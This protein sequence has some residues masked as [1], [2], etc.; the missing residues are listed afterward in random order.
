MHSVAF[1][2]AF[3]F[4]LSAFLNAALKPSA[5]A[6]ENAVED[7]SRAAH[8]NIFFHVRCFVKVDL[9]NV[10]LTCIRHECLGLA[11]RQSL[12]VLL[13]FSLCSYCI[14]V[15]IMSIYVQ[16]TMPWNVTDLCFLTLFKSS[17]LIFG[18]A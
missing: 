2:L 4:C 5:T 13:L 18:Q 11:S 15:M 12:E 7:R 17:V 1:P 3:F 9:V 16:C 10:L 14:I 6:V 8:E